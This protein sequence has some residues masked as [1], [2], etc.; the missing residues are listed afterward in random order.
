MDRKQLK[1]PP[2]KYRPIPFWS[3]NERLDT[4]ETK[5]QI[6]VMDKAGM[7]G[8]FM[9]ARGGLQTGYMSDE[10]FDNVKASIEESE[11]RGMY[12]W[13]YDENG[14][15]SGFGD[16]IVCG[17]GVE[18]Q[19]KYLRIEEGEGNTPY[20]ICNADGF[21]MYYEVNPFYV[22]TLDK[23]VIKEFLNTVHEKYYKEV[24]DSIQGF[25]T[26]EP[27]AA[28]TDIPWSLC[29]PDKY[30]QEY[31]DDILPKLPQL[32]KP[33]GEY[34]DTRMKFWRLV[35]K[36]FSESY[37]KQIYDWCSEHNLKLTGHLSGEVTMQGQMPPNGACMP[38]Y[39]YF[40]IPGM[41]WLGRPIG[42]PLIMH[43][44]VSAA[45][46]TG[47]TQILSET[48]GLCG[49]NVSFS[50]LR[51][52]FEWQMARGVNLLC[53]HLQG[54][55]LRGIRKRDYPPA[56]YYQQPWWKEYKAF[57]DSMSRIGMLIAEGKPDC[58]TL[59]MHPQTSVWMCYDNDKCDGLEF[60]Q[61]EF[62]G[63][64]EA[65]E[66]KHIQFHLG[67]EILMERHGRVEGNKLVIG[68]MEYDTVILPPHID[69]FENTKNVLTEFKENGGIITTAE[70]ICENDVIDNPEITY[71]KRVHKEFDV[72]YFVNSTNV[73]QTAKIKANGVELDFMTGEEKGFN[74]NHTFAPYDSLVVIEYRNGKSIPCE[75][76]SLASLSLD[77]EWEIA[78]CSENT[79]TLDYCDCYFD[80][81]LVEE[82]M[83]VI[84]IQELACKLKRK[85]NIRQVFK[86]EMEYIP[87]NIFLVCETPEN[88]RFKINGREA[89]F[90]DMG[91]FCDVS[92]RK[93]NISKYLKTGINEIE[94]VCDFVQSE[95]VY[96]DVENAPKCQSIRNK[97]TYDMEIESIY[98]A[99]DFSVRTPGEFEQLDKNAVRYADRFV[100]SK[101]QKAVRL[102]NI[103]QQGFPFFCGNMTVRK[104]I[105]VDDINKKIIF[106]MQGINAV[107]VKINGEKAETVIWN[108][109][110]MDISKHLKEGKNE[111][112]LTIYNNL[113]NLLGPHHLEEG[114]C[115]NVRP[116]SFF[117]GESLFVPWWM[118][119]LGWNDGY[120]FV[121]TSIGDVDYE[122]G[123]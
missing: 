39:E 11:K 64:I 110:D 60:Y 15:P 79:V 23:K 19:Q 83:P 106:N 1:N 61:N 25:F 84:S 104:T 38:H 65:L 17:L 88:F 36:L 7:G 121:E 96:E 69:F 27:E 49:H 97:L 67:D 85:V 18:Y 98:L 16:G 30:E 3:W 46:Q 45:M 87:E 109:S 113:R 86:A 9:H 81:K 58:R 76:K 99:G 74:K 20:T 28:N 118:K 6:G 115:L 29:L 75:P 43:Q 102:K 44:L 33:I 22:D 116:C 112:E 72:H 26:D 114:E 62:I 12:P 82:N 123:K 48:F 8:F 77:G 13:A 107:K 100:I 111:I 21:H 73:R 56:M 92:F 93:T 51:R 53:Q 54:Y 14:W 91:Y 119:P 57:N 63:I 37:M 95:K 2:K 90:E 32:F 52:I 34:R 78:E 71:L 41:D 120:C 103:E 50:E 101:P 40:H 122:S 5:R 35:T 80:G 42:S 89:V 108:H 55:S 47:K 10:W 31:G 24:G 105:S 59:V 4:G 68:E 94:L 117:K 70:E 66:K